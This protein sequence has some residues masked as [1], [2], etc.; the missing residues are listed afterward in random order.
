MS[1]FFDRL[2]PKLTVRERALLDKA[3]GGVH[4]TEEEAIALW[5]H[6][7]RDV[8][9]VIIADCH[10]SGCTGLRKLAALQTP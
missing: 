9:A 2:I 4:F 6:A 10:C 1:S 7:T 5:K 8:P 3:L